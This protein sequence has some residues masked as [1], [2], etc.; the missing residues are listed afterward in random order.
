MDELACVGNS[1][2]TTESDALL[3]G[4]IFAYNKA[5]RVNRACDN[6]QPSEAAFQVP[7]YARRAG[8][9]KVPLAVYWADL[10]LFMS[11]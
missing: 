7:P 5:E 8:Y 6:C 1:S 10:D 3:A 9:I 4:D 2:I 11:R